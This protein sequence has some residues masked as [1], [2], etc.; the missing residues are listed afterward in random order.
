[1]KMYEVQGKKYRLYKKDDIM[2][3][4]NNNLKVCN[5]IKGNKMEKRDLYDEKRNFTGE[6]YIKRR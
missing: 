4:I 3:N 6:N 2:E 5:L 1:M